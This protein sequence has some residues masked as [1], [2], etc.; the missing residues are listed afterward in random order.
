MAAH[1]AVS[2]NG[3]GARFLALVFNQV[4]FSVPWSL[5][6]AARLI[7]ES[8]TLLSGPVQPL[9]GPESMCRD[10]M[11]PE[12]GS[13]MRSAGHTRGF[14]QAWFARYQSTVFL[15]PSSNLTL[16]FQPIL[17]ILSQLSE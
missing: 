12:G 8:S 17:R 13:T 10:K 2:E 6:S 14:H 15:R 7:L 4:L 1:I 11:V 3:Y 16:G 9:P 5:P